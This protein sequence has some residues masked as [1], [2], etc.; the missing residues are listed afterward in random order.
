M[1]AATLSYITPKKKGRIGEDKYHQIPTARKSITP[2][3]AA[4]STTTTT[5]SNQHQIIPFFSNSIKENFDAP[6]VVRVSIQSVR[7]H[8]RKEKSLLIPI[9]VMRLIN[10]AQIAHCVICNT[11]NDLTVYNK[12]SDTDKT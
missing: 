8:A 6:H 4:E 9:K 12:N 7:S 3:T 10:N 5:N 11:N 2:T 1:P